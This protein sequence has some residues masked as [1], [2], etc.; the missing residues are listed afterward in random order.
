MNTKC[1]VIIDSCC[2]LPKETIDRE[3][4][5]LLKFP[6]IDSKGT[7]IDDMFQSVSPEEFYDGMRNGE[8]PS[9]AQIPMA[10]ITE[11]YQW[12][13]EQGKPA[14]FICF[15]SGLSGTYDT[16]VLLRDQFVA[17]HP[18]FELHVVDSKLASIAEG[19]L[20]HGALSEREKGLSAKELAAWVEEAQYFINCSFMIDDLEVLRRGGRIPSSVAFAGS[21]LD[22]KPLLT[23]GLEGTLSLM[24]MARGRKKGMKQMI[25]H[26]EKTRMQSV[27]SSRIIVA[28]A[29]AKKD[30]DKLIELIEKS[31]EDAL[32][33]E[34]VVGPVIG[35]HVGPGMVAMVFWG[36]DRRDSGSLADRIANKVKGK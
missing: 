23:F 21:K 11:A 22:L 4:V 16:C 30:L 17:E 26:Y 18:D 28:H 29:D 1:N 2:D 31:D 20:V 33:L 34:S 8:E 19:F 13:Y 7:H 24:G 12:A 25:E 9:T 14:V 15:S 3:G 32:I 6:Y 27:N 5:Y 36:S 35:S 10:D